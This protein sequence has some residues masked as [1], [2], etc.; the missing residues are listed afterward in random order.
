M[1]TARVTLSGTAEPVSP[2]DRSDEL[3]TAA[4]LGL[5][6]AVAAAAHVIE[7]IVMLPVGP[8]RLGLANALTITAMYRLGI[9]YGIF[10]SA[11]RALIG[12]AAFGTLFSPVFPMNFGGALAGAVVMAVVVHVSR[13]RAHPVPVS[14][15]GAA[16]HNAVQLLYIYMVFDTTRVFYLAFPMAV[17]TVASGT[18]V[19]LITRVLTD[20]FPAGAALI[21][22][23]RK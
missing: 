3:R 8:F 22:T 14:L 13:R 2:A 4:V 11:T 12:A 9:K 10:I 17:W 15:A 20:R 19:G 6:V 23:E 5:L 16:A 1:N 18:V 7:G 21:I